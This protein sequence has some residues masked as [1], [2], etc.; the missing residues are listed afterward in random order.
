MAPDKMRR[1]LSRPFLINYL[2]V[3]VVTCWIPLTTIRATMTNELGEVQAETVRSIPLYESYY[4]FFTSFHTTYL[5]AILL[6][7][8]LCFAISFAV[9]W[10]VLRADRRAEAAAPDA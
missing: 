6:H 4:R 7:W 3:L 9:W 5:Q 2:V 1:I 8:G 10:F